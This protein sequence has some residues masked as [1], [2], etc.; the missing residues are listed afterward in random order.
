M[1]D[2]T[3]AF[4]TGEDILQ[5]CNLAL[6]FRQ[7]IDNLLTLQGSQL[8]QLHREDGVCLYIIYREKGF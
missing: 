8:A 7:L 1:D 5:I 6:D 2:L 3:L 4:L